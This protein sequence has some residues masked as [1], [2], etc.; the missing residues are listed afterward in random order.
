MII[1]LSRQLG[2]GARSTGERLCQEFN[3]Q[4]LDN[5]LIPM[6]ARQLRTD[7]HS[8]ARLDEHPDPLLT[9]VLRTFYASAPETS[10]IV[11]AEPEVTADDVARVTQAVITE[12]AAHES[13]VVTG[14]GARWVVGDRDDALHVHL[15]APL[16]IRVRRVARK[17]NIGQQAAE[18]LVR[19]ADHDRAAYIRRYYHAV[20]GDPEN[21][22]LV[23]NT[24]WL[25]L[26]GVV[27]IIKDAAIRISGESL[28]TL[29]P[30]PV[31]P[32]GDTTERSR[33][34]QT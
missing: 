14:R 25:P 28:Q 10:M 34:D 24:G 20:W 29:A 32:E 23:I 1:T 27:A 22:H 12:M 6:V 16:P 15:V 4:F 33:P 11:D 18:Q 19:Q 13:L 8:V 5:T 31:P 3:C 9:R 2:A 7:E 30:S 21:Y 26:D 17:D